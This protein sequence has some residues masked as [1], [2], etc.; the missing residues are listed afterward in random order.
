M[1]YQ[2]ILDMSCDCAASP[3]KNDQFDH[4]ITGDLHIIKEIGLRKLCS[5][6]TKFRDTPRL[7]LSS[8]K[9]QFQNDVD[10]LVKKISK[11]FKIT[12]SALK[13]WKKF[14]IQQ[15]NSKLQLNSTL[16]K[17]P[18]PTLSNVACRKELKALQERYV[19]TV[20]DKASGN[21]AFT[22]R[23]F[24]F[25]KLAEE[26]GLNNATPGNDTYRFCPEDEQAVCDR[27]KPILAKFRITP[28]DCQHKI[29]LLYQT[30]KFHK[31]PPK[32]RF[33]AGNVSTITSQLD[34][35]VA[36]IL[37]MCKTH[38]RN[39]S[40]V[41][42]NYS[43]IKHCFD[44]ET[45]TEVKNMFDDAY[46]K[47]D[48]ITIND[49]ST[50]YTLFDHDHLLH[51]IKWLLETLSKN[52]GKNCIKLDYKN[53]RWVSN[54]NEANS[55]TIGETLEMIS[56]LV[57]ETY[58]KAFGHIFQQVKGII[59]GGKI[60]GWLSDCS[61][62]VD[63]FLY[64]RN[65]MSNGLN[66][67]AIRLKFFRRYRDD[68]TTLNC[69]NFL[70]IAKDIYPPSLSLTQE[71]DE[72]HKANVLDMEVN[73]SDSICHTKIFCKTD[74]FPFN[75][76]TFPFLESNID[77]DL[78]YRVFYSQIIRFQR[79]CSHRTDFED[80]TRLLGT[81]LLERGYRIHV[82][83]RQ[84]CRVIDKYIKEF[85][86]WI[87]PLDLRAWFKQIFN[88]QPTG[89]IPPR[90]ISMAFSQPHSSLDNISVNRAPASQP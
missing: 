89:N 24:Y 22:C 29:A 49:F 19:I 8:I 85:Q 59:M 62:M 20:V 42:E 46:G 6:G 5:Y 28:P 15:F 67:Q 26:L 51:N 68:C 40:R 77:E 44:V 38:F 45:S 74:H 79:L 60:S 3:F 23:K 2:D 63:E 87:I 54:A 35:K 34:E 9:N 56:F 10:C 13:A 72:P 36:K 47:V 82:L 70:D 53:A 21:Y 57:K 84:F 7:N 37:K 88:N 75:V 50:L 61:L 90:P 48:S 25:L 1:S 69:Q 55:F 58:I 31:N 65:K 17:F 14:F 73:I 83:E 66:E 12:F 43:G 39:L 86:K 76:I 32:M 81:A 16:R 18:S 11:K 33:I 64:I 71:N 30:P 52:S 4:V 80:R 27:L 41:Y 78:C